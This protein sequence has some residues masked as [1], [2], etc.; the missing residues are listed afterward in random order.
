[1][2]LCSFKVNACSVLLKLSE[3]MHKTQ[4]KESV[5]LAFAPDGKWSIKI[6]FTEVEIL[7]ELSA[8]ITTPCEKPLRVINLHFSS[9][10]FNKGIKSFLGAYKLKAKEM[11]LQVFDDRI[12]FHA[13]NTADN[14][15]GSITIKACGE[16]A[17]SDE[18]EEEVE[19]EEKKEEKEEEESA[20]K[21]SP[22][23]KKRKHLEKKDGIQNDYDHIFDYE[24]PIGSQELAMGLI[25]PQK[26]K[27]LFEK[28][29]LRLG[30][31]PN[32]SNRKTGV[33]FA[34]L[35]E[36]E[37][38]ERRAICTSEQ[39]AGIDNYEIQFIKSVVDQLQKTV[40]AL[41]SLLVD[42]DKQKKKRK[43]QAIEEDEDEDDDDQSSALFLRLSQDTNVPI[44][45]KMVSDG[46]VVRL[47]AASV[48][49]EN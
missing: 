47:L 25:S 49:P 11:S 8:P 39:L 7:A 9:S 3:I 15:I 29:V 4:A 37:T 45:V 13:F 22:P 30:I 42:D 6:R 35:K 41:G 40:K 17:E 46:I 48:A 31:E 12:E 26:D 5:K 43:S 38:Q 28:C 24:I 19:D 21:Q 32:K 34:V 33:L 18:D 36:D 23:K 1:M 10:A 2:A 27:T 44:G 16:T 20:V 14:N